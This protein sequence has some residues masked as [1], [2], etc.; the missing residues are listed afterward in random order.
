MDFYWWPERQLPACGVGVVEATKSAF[1]TSIRR[2]RG[3]RPRAQCGTIQDSVAP[4]ADLLA[5]KSCLT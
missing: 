2:I 3:L 5:P 4:A 1:F